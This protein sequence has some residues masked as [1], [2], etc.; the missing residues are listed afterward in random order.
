MA[1]LD[2]FFPRVFSLDKSILFCEYIFSKKLLYIRVFFWFSSH[3]INFFF[4]GG[5]SK[6]SDFSI[7]F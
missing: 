1:L 2:K 6:S 5:G 4:W 7:G 3:Q